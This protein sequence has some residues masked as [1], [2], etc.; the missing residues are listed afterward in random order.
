MIK[1]KEREVVFT[2]LMPVFFFFLPIKSWLIKRVFDFNAVMARWP[3]R[4]ILSLLLVRLF[5]A[6]RKRISFE[7]IIVPQA[8]VGFLF[9]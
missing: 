3:N 6:K 9:F 7:D 4:S 8:E 1:S 5:K 2:N